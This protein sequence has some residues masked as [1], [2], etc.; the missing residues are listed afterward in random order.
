MKRDLVFITSFL[1]VVLLGW[2]AGRGGKL[3]PGPCRCEC[4]KEAPAP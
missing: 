2:L 1:V 4:V 3:V